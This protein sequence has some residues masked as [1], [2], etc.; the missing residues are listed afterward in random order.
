MDKGELIMHCHFA[1]LHFSSG[2]PIQYLNCL[3]F[4]SS[5][6]NMHTKPQSGVLNLNVKIYFLV[7]KLCIP[8]MSAVYFYLGFLSVVH[9]YGKTR[10][11][12]SIKLVDCF[13]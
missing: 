2:L 11:S 1:L 8:K 6:M 7:Q 5:E 9:A 12:F 13:A 3:V 10:T 4:I